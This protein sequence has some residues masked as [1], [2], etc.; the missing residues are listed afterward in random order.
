MPQDDSDDDD[1]DDEDDDGGNQDDGSSSSSSS[2]DDND[3]TAAA[4]AAA[5]GHSPQPIRPTVTVPRSD[6]HSYANAAGSPAK[7]A[8]AAPNVLMLV[9]PMPFFPIK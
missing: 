7:I 6:T 4:H 3:S 2:S 1:D 5:I 9:L 8:A